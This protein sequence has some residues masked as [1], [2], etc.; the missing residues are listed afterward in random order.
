MDQSTEFSIAGYKSLVAKFINANYRFSDFTQKNSNER[1]VIFRHDI[2]FS[3]QGASLTGTLSTFVS[4]GTPTDDFITADTSI[5]T[6]N[7]PIHLSDVTV[8][9]L[10]NIEEK[11][12]WFES[13]NPIKLFRSKVKNVSNNTEIKKLE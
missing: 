13:L 10:Q 6:V 11:E 1:V 12:S 8:N 2:D 7:V 4:S 3:T 9:N 5:E